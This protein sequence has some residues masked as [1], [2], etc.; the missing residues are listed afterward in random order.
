MEMYQRIC[1][2]HV[3]IE[4]LRLRLGHQTFDEVNADIAKNLRNTFKATRVKKEKEDFEAAF[5]VAHVPS[6]KE[7]LKGFDISPLLD[8][9]LQLG[10]IF[11]KGQ[12][13]ELLQMEWVKR[14]E[15]NEN[16]Q[17]TDVEFR[18][19]KGMKIGQ[20]KLEIKRDEQA[21]EGKNKKIQRQV[22]QGIAQPFG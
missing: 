20:L 7:N 18:R 15:N 10:K 21:Q 14:V 12:N 9:K 2:V 1:D 8:S 17:L 16:R 11:N 22:L 6:A 19:I 5:S 4:S 3:D 13:V